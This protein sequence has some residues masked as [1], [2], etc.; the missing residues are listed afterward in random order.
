MEIGTIYKN[1]WGDKRIPIIKTGEDIIYIEHLLDNGYWFYNP[2]KHRIKETNL[3]Q[4]W[5]PTD[6]KLDEPAIKRL[7]ESILLELNVDWAKL[8]LKSSE[9]MHI[10]INDIK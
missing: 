5:Y 3:K 6:M 1:K 4:K 8:C 2:Y 10:G 9:L 7:E